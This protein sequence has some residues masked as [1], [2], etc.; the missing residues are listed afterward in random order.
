MAAFN[1]LMTPN[2]FDNMYYQNLQR[3]LGLLDSDHALAVDKRTKPYVEMYAANETKF[4]QDF[5]H[6][7]EKLS[8]YKVKTGRKGE[9]RHKCDAFNSIKP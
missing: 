2:K 3:G 7:M 6:A 5:A 8:I 4:F 9:V 1:D